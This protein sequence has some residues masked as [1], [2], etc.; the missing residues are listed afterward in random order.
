M[1]GGDGMICCTLHFLT[2]TCPERLTPKRP[3]FKKS[4]S[5]HPPSEATQK[6]SRVAFHDGV[7][8]NVGPVQVSYPNEFTASHKLWHDTL[9][10]VGVETNDNHL[11]GS[12]TGCW[13][14]VVSVDPRTATRSYAGTA[15]YK[16]VASRPNLFVLMGAEVLKVLLAKK[17][18]DDEC[19]AEGVLFAHGGTQFSA[20]ASRE[21]IISAGSVQSPQILELSGIGGRDILTAARIPVKVDNPN[22]G[23]HLQDHLS[24]SCPPSASSPPTC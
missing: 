4:E 1:R 15:Y 19:K 14:S 3:F 16:P 18:D 20:F 8:G 23:E 12:N 5:F 7:V 11:A 2:R 22:V 24:L 10:A 9:N 6:T 13:T 21:V 17:D